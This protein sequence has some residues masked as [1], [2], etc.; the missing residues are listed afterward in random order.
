[1]QVWTTI[2]ITHATALCA[3]ALSFFPPSQIPKPELTSM[4]I[5]E[6]TN[7]QGPNTKLHRALFYP[8]KTPLWH[9]LTHTLHF[10]SFLFFLSCFP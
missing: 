8:C 9:A 10:A 4:T 5:H 7:P 1:M 3:I 6:V 2:R